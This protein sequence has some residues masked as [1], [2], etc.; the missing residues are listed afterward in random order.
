[1][2]FTAA[3]LH[4]LNNYRSS[5]Q[6][7]G[8]REL[9][10]ITEVPKN[11]QQFSFRGKLILIALV[12]DYHAVMIDISPGVHYKE[13]ATLIVVVQTSLSRSSYMDMNIVNTK[14]LKPQS[15]ERCVCMS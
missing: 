10:G 8:K 3:P 2:L 12:N 6:S 14:Q 5:F 15:H 11:L 9:Q 1:M 4:V 7:N 13:C